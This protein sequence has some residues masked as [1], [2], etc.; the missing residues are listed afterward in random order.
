MD[1]DIPEVKV[2]IFARKQ[3]SPSGVAGW[4]ECFHI[5][6]CLRTLRLNQRGRRHWFFAVRMLRGPR[7]MA[8]ELLCG[9]V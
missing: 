1:G 8:E 2:F 4:T 9:E 6:G 5:R 3:A 7:V